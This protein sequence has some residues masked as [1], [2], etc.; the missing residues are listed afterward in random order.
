MAATSNATC[1][2]CPE[3]G[4]D[5]CAS[6]ANVNYCSKRCQ[7]ID[8]KRGHPAVCA[9]HLAEVV[10]SHVNL[11]LSH[12][13]RRAGG[14]VDPLLLWLDQLARRP[15]QRP[16]YAALKKRMIVLHLSKPTAI[17]MNDLVTYLE[18]RVTL[19]VMKLHTN[20]FPE[21]SADLAKDPSYVALMTHADGPVA[22]TLIAELVEA[23]ERVEVQPH[24]AFKAKWDAAE[25]IRISC[26]VSCGTNIKG[27]RVTILELTT[28]GAQ[29]TPTAAAPSSSRRDEAFKAPM[30]AKQAA[31]AI[32]GGAP[33]GSFG[34]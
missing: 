6:C 27:G 15:I 9:N 10:L 21:L 4:R 31:A 26:Q 32:N 33:Y 25:T 34:S 14:F 12:D 7:T 29:P 1:A 28:K 19:A 2:V 24:S 22:F 20:V 30:N 13:V 23:D 18:E 5:R 17:L 8:W 3:I 16:Q 11:R